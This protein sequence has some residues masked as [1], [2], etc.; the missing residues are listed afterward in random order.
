MQPL[1]SNSKRF[2][3]DCDRYQSAIDKTTDPQLKLEMSELL[4]KLVFEVRNI[5]SMHNDMLVNMNA[6][7]KVNDGR[8]ALISIRKELEKRVAS[9]IS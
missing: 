6:T 8:S 2:K 7:S 9:L 5:D 3:E 4:R 1:I